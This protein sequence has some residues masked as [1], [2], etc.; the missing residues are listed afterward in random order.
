[1]I[2]YNVKILP[3]GTPLFYFV[4]VP[5]FYYRP[6]EESALNLELMREMDTHYMEHPEKGAKRMHTLWSACTTK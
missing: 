1:M 6:R 3:R 2:A 4:D 5:V